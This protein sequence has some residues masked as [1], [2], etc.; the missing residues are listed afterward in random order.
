MNQKQKKILA[1]AGLVVGGFVVYKV[2]IEHHSPSMFDRAM[3]RGS[4]P[5]GGPPHITLP[6]PHTGPILR[7]P[8]YGP[9]HPNPVMG[10]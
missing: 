2:F 8:F 7:L 5:I 3:G 9:L 10:Y 4:G 1:L 6:P